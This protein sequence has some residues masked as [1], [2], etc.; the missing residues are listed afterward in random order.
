MVRQLHREG[1]RFMLSIWPNMDESTENYREFRDRGL[2][3]PGSNI[4]DPLRGEGRA[5]Y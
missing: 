3:L 1:V 4:Y 5:L 2:L